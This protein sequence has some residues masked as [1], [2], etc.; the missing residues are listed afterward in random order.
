MQASSFFKNNYK[1]AR[2]LFIK[3]AIK[4]NFNIY[5]KQLPN[6][7]GPFGEGL[8]I[9]VATK[10]HG[11]KAI[12]IISATH[13]TEGYAG[14]AIQSAFLEDFEEQNYKI[15]LIHALN[16]FGF[17][18]NTRFNEDNI[19]IN[20]NF[21]EDFTDLPQNPN[22]FEIHNILVTQD[23]NDEIID[24]SHSQ[25]IQYGRENGFDKLRQ[26]LTQGQY[27]YQNGFYFGG[28][29]KSWSY[30]QLVNILDKELENIDEFALIDI[31]TGLGNFAMPTLISSSDIYSDD[32][33]N[34]SKVFGLASST[35]GKDC[36]SAPLNGCLENFLHK[37]YINKKR[38]IIALEFGTT[39]PLYALKATQ[40]NIWTFN[41][42]I[43]QTQSGYR[44]NCK[45]LGAFYVNNDDWKQKIIENGIK[46]I[47]SATNYFAAL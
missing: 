29:D 43:I 10:G 6:Q 36:V 7:N 30:L 35:H 40:M 31:H 20:R 28:L 14:S 37:R 34:S 47:K 11:N 41:A 19:D 9:D 44:N 2:N 17:A 45:Y 38:S 8:F 18:W 22:Y 4:A 46:T 1:D 3:Q 16:P 32:F 42:G 26:S 24:K 5:N 12:I 23:F 21:L 15:I 27:E 33:R 39:D 13:G 25:L